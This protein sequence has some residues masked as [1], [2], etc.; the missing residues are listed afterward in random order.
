MANTSI[1]QALQLRQSASYIDTRVP[2]LANYQTN[3]T[4]LEYDMN[5]IRSALNNYLNRSGTTFPTGDWYLDVTAPTVFS[6]DLGAT[7]AVR[8]INAVGN[9]LWG[10]QRKRILKRTWMVGVDV[11][12]AAGGDLYVILPLADIP[13]TTTAAVGAVPTLGTVVSDNSGAFG[14]FSLLQ[15][16]SS[17]DLEPKS[18]VFLV[19][20]ATGEQ[21]LGASSGDLIWGL[22]QGEN[23]TDGYTI[24]GTTP[25][26]VQISFVRHNP[27]ND[28]LVSAAANDLDGITFDY[29]YVLRDAF[30]D[31]PEESWLGDSFADS[32]VGSTTRQS[33]YNN[34]GT[35]IVLTESNS[36]LDIGG[37]FTWEIGNSA[38]ASLMLLTEAGASSTMAIGAAV[39]SYTNSAVTNIFTNG[40]QVDSSNP[41]HIGN[42]T[43]G[44]DTIL[45]GGTAATVTTDSNNIT[46]STTTSGG[47]LV[48]SA[49]LVDIQAATAVSIDSSGGAINVGADD[50]AQ[51]INIGTS[52]TAARTIT[53]G[54]DNV[55]SAVDF[56]SGTG[57]FSF[58]STIADTASLIDL[59]TTG[60]GAATIGLFIGDATE[61]VP[62]GRVTGVIG[63]L[64]IQ[65]DGTL[66]QNT[67]GSTAWTQFAAA[68]GANLESV[69][70]AQGSTPTTTDTDIIVGFTTNAF[71][72]VRDSG[73]GAITKTIEDGAGNE[74]EVAAAVTD[75]NS[76]TTTIDGTTLAV[77]ETGLI[78]LDSS[79]GAISLGANAASD[80]TVTSADLTLKTDTLGDILITSAGEV[81]ATGTCVG[82]HPVSGGEDTSSFHSEME[83]FQ[84]WGTSAT[85]ANGSF[86]G[87][88]TQ[89]VSA[90][91]KEAGTWVVLSTSATVTDTITATTAAVTSTT[92][93]NVAVASSAL[94]SVGDLVTITGSAD[95]CNDDLYEVASIPDATNIRLRGPNGV[96]ARV[97]TFTGLDL[98]AAG[99]GGTIQK[100]TVS[101]IQ[102]GTDGLWEGGTGSTTGIVFTNFQGA[103]TLQ[104]AYVNG[105]TI[106]VESGEDPLQFLGTADDTTTVLTLTG[107]THTAATAQA[108]LEVTGTANRSGAL[109]SITDASTESGNA[110]F[111]DNSGDGPAV[112][113]QNTSSGNAFRVTDGS[114]DHFTVDASGSSTFT[115]DSNGDFTVTTTGATGIIDIDAVAAITLDSSAGAISLDANA[116][117][118][119]SVTDASLSLQTLGTTAA[120]VLIST[121]SGNA[122]AGEIDLTAGNGTTT[123]GAVDVNAGTG[124]TTGAGGT[125]A[126]NAGNGGATSGAGGGLSVGAGNA[127]GVGNGGATV[128]S[129]GIGGTTGSGGDFTVNAGDGG[130]VSGPAGRVFVNGGDSV[131]SSA[132]N[133]TIAGGTST[134]ST[135][136]NVTIGAG[137]S[138][139]GNGANVRLTSGAGSAGNGTVVL[140]SALD[141]NVAAVDPVVE[142]YNQ[143]SGTGGGAQI[144]L[145]TEDG[146][147]AA[148]APTVSADSASLYFQQRATTTP[149]LFLNTSTGASGTTWTEI[150][151]GI[152]T[153]ESAYVAGNTATVTDAD[154]SF[155]LANTSTTITTTDMFT[156]TNSPSVAT[157]G[158]AVVIAHAPGA[159]SS[160]DTVNISTGANVTGTSFFLDNLGSGSA[161]T[162][163]D[164]SSDVFDI[165]ATGAITATPTSGTNFTV[166]VAGAGIIS[167]DAAAASNFTVA[168][169]N[170]VLDTTGA[171]QTR[172][173]SEGR[174]WISTDDTAGTAE[175]WLQTN[176]TGLTLPTSTA[177]ADIYLYTG[178]TSG[179]GS[180]GDTYV[181]SGPA[182]GSGDSGAVIAGS[183]SASSGNTGTASLYSGDSSSA[184]TGAVS[185]SSGSAETN[186]GAVSVSS[187]VSVSGG[188]TGAVTV[189]SGNA[190]AIGGDVGDVT[191]SAGSSPRTDGTGEGNVFVTGGANTASGLAGSVTVAGGS[192]ASGATANTGA[193]TLVGGAHAGSGDGG[194]LFLRGGASATGSSG[195]IFLSTAGMA[196]ITESTAI[197][198]LRNQGSG[199]GAGEDVSFFTGTSDP[200]TIVTADAGSMFFRDTGTGAEVWV[201]TSTGSGTAW[202]QVDIGGVSGSLEAAWLAATGATTPA[203]GGGSNGFTGTV[204]DGTTYL[205]TDTDDTEILLSLA[206]VNGADVVTLGHQA[207]ASVL[208]LDSGSGGTTID[209]T[210]DISIGVVTAA[211]IRI[212][213]DGSG[214]K[215]A[216]SLSMGSE[217]FITAAADTTM[218]LSTT[219]STT[220][221]GGDITATAGGSS[222]VTGSGGGLDLNTGSAL[223]ATGGGTGGV[224]TLDTGSGADGTIGAV[225]VVAGAGGS[226]TIILGTGGDGTGS[227][228][229]AQGAAGADGGAWSVLGG[230]GGAGE[231]NVGVGLAG[232]GGTV[233]FTGGAGGAGSG[234]STGSEVAADGGAGA[235]VN[236]TGGAGGAGQLGTVD[237]AAAGEAGAIALTAGA[238]GVGAGTGDNANGGNI[239][240][241]PTIAGVGGS[242]AAGVD[243]FVNINSASPYSGTVL[244]L[245]TGG[246]SGSIADLLVGSVVPGSGDDAK[247][248]SLYHF[249]DNTTAATGGRLYMQADADG[250]GGTGDNWREVSTVPAVG[251]RQFVQ[252]VLNRAITGSGTQAGGATGTNIRE[253][254][255]TPAIT[256]PVREAS[257]TFDTQAEIYFNGVLM[258]N[259]TGN[260]VNPGTVTGTGNDVTKDIWL[261]AGTALSIGDIVTVKYSNL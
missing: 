21:V 200:N 51:A 130:S 92:D 119:F 114:T 18:L 115:P 65:D 226:G 8:G 189:S 102:T 48:A 135:G 90:T 237:P 58:D 242:G 77:N 50:N 17:N 132:G 82:I 190:T 53:I 147:V 23:T 251:A 179:T 106:T 131:D 153:L 31:C 252:G 221:D 94:F 134:S 161:F 59:T 176:G 253:G 79:A 15:V 173:N 164:G 52:A 171:G 86:V 1:P 16:D 207:E 55:A 247:A 255:F 213:I 22:M 98:T 170:L 239:N 85:T 25:N 104:Q 157:T 73:G 224:F 222:F 184:A 168:G 248:G 113:I 3:A 6:T 188:N 191:V 211:D 74:F 142:I 146:L 209:S 233:S 219:A 185:V 105:A 214:T 66:W 165:A 40:V 9:D 234:T 126:F 206:S 7:D 89:R 177:S 140:R 258:F 241:V 212:G 60:T 107:A 44:T 110:F 43:S 145:F 216:D 38:S 71:W 11:T 127:V 101:V 261:Q 67:D 84:L 208:V 112:V 174:V 194:D 123:G 250:A 225:P 116:A 172:I 100:A 87:H 166:D 154:G 24:T 118:N 186:S 236:L 204:S 198:T 175:V 97:E 5:S 229:A 217:S 162:V 218:S 243:G 244:R 238:A 124:T 133:V 108:A 63:S 26:R 232:D 12:I 28:D 197:A 57:A 220:T 196:A 192:V 144:Q 78:S 240:L 223:A 47:V 109:V 45:F 205:I 136:G 95:N 36:T 13:S 137:S 76:A 139:S 27:D 254:D 143:G 37:A 178:A 88:N 160:G 4:D 163:Q 62:N 169:A 230:A 148:A 235:K 32:G 227:G 33:V 141:A 158:D 167:L 93:A 69:L 111:V 75:I 54:N 149:R 138:T 103:T 61:G 201:N 245:D 228:T 181:N 152:S 195:S 121:A 19:D 14:A 122:T 155:A 182:A 246:T 257:L 68:G 259:G 183:G 151:F 231:A 210:G 203:L 125:A 41:I 187:G 156:V 10:I 117:S 29:G 34:Q 35:G 215:I 64:F 199:T 56:D 91:A 20:Q 46:V 70:N 120:D 96:T 2:S 49:G 83:R 202:S 260:D 30:E 180:S 80:F 129:S 72:E 150:E 256:L 39:S 81:D 159:S 193:V 99:A 42:A 249:N 128:V